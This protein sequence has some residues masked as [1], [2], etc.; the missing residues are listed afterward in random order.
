M[1]FRSYNYGSLKLSDT[2]RKV[3]SLTTIGNVIFVNENEN[4]NVEKRENNEFVNENENE[5]EKMMKTKTKTKMPKYQN[6][7][8]NESASIQYAVQ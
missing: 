3:A 4:E 7:S 1:L 2:F 6:L 5:N 8:L